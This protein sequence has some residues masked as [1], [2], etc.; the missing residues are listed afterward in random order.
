MQPSPVS[1]P[2]LKC[3]VQS[4]PDCAEH[5]TG[6][7]PQPSSKH[8][9]SLPFCSER[10]GILALAMANCT[11]ASSHTVS[12]ALEPQSHTWAPGGARCQFAVYY[13]IN[14]PGNA[15]VQWRGTQHHVV[16]FA[17]S[18]LYEVGKYT[19]QMHIRNSSRRWALL[20]HICKPFQ[21]AG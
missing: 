20:Q 17:D 6:T 5:P 21:C 3:A 18:P 12:E 9:P 11:T 4:P 19:T 16:N 14:R 15:S 7:A 13:V 2:L 1:S 8:L 10:A